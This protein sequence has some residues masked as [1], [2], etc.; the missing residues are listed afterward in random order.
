MTHRILSCV[1]LV[2]VFLVLGLA[3]APQEDEVDSDLMAMGE[4]IYG[5]ECARCHGPSG[6]GT[7]GV[8][9]ELDGNELVLG[10]PDAVISIVIEGPG[11]MPAFG[12]Q[13]DD[14]EIAAVVT[15]IRN[16]WGNEASPVSAGD[17]AAAR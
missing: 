14:Q 4:T 9:P 17:V 6:L 3:C 15:Y 10:D 11:R 13:L 5:Q 12:N 7:E 2:I 1:S 8:Y 16:A